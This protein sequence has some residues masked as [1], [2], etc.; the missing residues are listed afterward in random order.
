MLELTVTDVK[1]FAYCARIPYYSYVQPVPVPR[2]YKVARGH[3]VQAALEALEQRRTLRRYGVDVGERV[4]GLRVRSERLG[5]S[6]RLDVAVRTPA[7]CHPVDFKDTDGSVR[8]NHV[9]Q[10]AAYAL[11]LEEQLGLPAPSGFV[12]LVPRQD[13]VE[14]PLGERERADVEAALAAIRA[15]VAAESLPE[16]TAVRARCEGCEF[17]NFCADIW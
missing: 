14:V 8:R 3:D 12:Y 5:L 17:R 10:L 6:G 15:F 1:Q 11:M 9:L 2:P 13:V 16:A 4:F 7:S